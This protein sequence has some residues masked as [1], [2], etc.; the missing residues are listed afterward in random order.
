MNSDEKSIYFY[1][2]CSGPG[3]IQS[4]IIRL[5]IEGV[6]LNKSIFLIDHNGSYLQNQ[7]KDRCPEA[8]S[9]NVFLVDHISEFV[10][11]TNSCI[12]VFNW[13]LP[14][15][16]EL[17]SSTVANLD[18]VYWDVH[19]VSIKQA[20]SIRLFGKRLLQFNTGKILKNLSVEKRLFTIDKVSELYIQKLSNED[21]SLL[22]TGIPVQAESALGIDSDRIYKSSQ[23]SINIVYIGRAVNW[24]VYPF[25]AAVELLKKKYSKKI[26]IKIYTDCA[27]DFNGLLAG[28]FSAEQSIQVFE[29]YPVSEI[30]KRERNWVTLSIGMGTSQFE[31]FL[32]GVPTLLI[33]A[34]IN[35]EVMKYIEPMWV[36]LMPKYVFGFDD[37]SLATISSICDVRH[38]M[39]SKSYF[40][41]LPSQLSDVSESASNIERI[42]SPGYILTLIFTFLNGSRSSVSFLYGSY[43]FKI[44]YKWLRVVVFIKKLIDY[45][46]RRQE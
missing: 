12:I 17:K 25:V 30:I 24:K 19:S 8:W 21:I 23:H 38:A 31:L 4:I 11:P 10:F 18:Y 41:W 39:L 9:G 44:I 2:P 7:I 37:E 1:F 42:Y 29:G 36:H 14:L 45:I 3:G 6:A 34:T 32:L 20:F 5:L 43:T 22:V 26:D 33:P 16:L 40:E 46:F 27:V 28:S 35:V 15:L 13:Q